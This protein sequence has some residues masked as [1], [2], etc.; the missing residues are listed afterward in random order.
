MAARELPDPELLRKLLRYEPET[1]K[2]FWLPRPVELFPDARACKV[3]NTRYSGCEAFKTVDTDGYK[4]GRLF[5][6]GTKAHRVIWAIVYGVWPSEQIDHINGNPSDNRLVNLRQASNT[7]NGRNQ[8]KR[9]TNI[10]GM[11][12]VSFDLR[13]R[14]WRAFIRVDGRQI[15][16][17]NF[18][19]FEDAAKA[20]LRAELDYGFHPNHGRD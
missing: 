1:G 5:T 17:G 19:G 11:M 18:A 20:R 10:S 15:H 14:R 3:W 12:C 4:T 8:K 13:K 9:I 6:I 7:Q 16:L 2:L